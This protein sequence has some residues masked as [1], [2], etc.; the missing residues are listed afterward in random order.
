[1][2]STPRSMTIVDIRKFAQLVSPP[3]VFCFHKTDVFRGIR[4]SLCVSPRQCFRMSVCVQNT[5]FCQSAGGGI[6]SHLVTA[7]GLSQRVVDLNHWT[8]PP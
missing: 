7:L 2:F 1:M 3:T 4:E 6:K 5:S 8:R